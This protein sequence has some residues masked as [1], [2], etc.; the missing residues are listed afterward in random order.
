MTI[1]QALAL[2]EEKI[3]DLR[4]TFRLLME[5]NHDIKN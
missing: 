3:N 4:K 1:S 5:E 2:E